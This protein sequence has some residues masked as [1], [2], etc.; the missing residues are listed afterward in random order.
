MKNKTKMKSLFIVSALVIAL[1]G[2]FVPSLVMA[3]NEGDASA[4]PGAGEEAGPS[5]ARISVA[6][7]QVSTQHADGGEWA[8][9]TVNAPLQ[10]GDSV[11]TGDRSRTEVQF[12]YSNVMRLDQN[13]AAKIADFTSSRVQIQF[14]QGLMSYSVLKGGGAEAEIDTPSV[15]VRPLGE[16]EYRIQIDPNSQQTFVTVQ[17]G[18]AEVSTPQGSQK[19]EAGQVMVIQGTDNPQFQVNNASG[20]DEFDEWSQNRD[21][22]ILEAKSW[23][24]TNRNYTGSGDLDRYGRW[25]DAPGY[26]QVWQPYEQSSDWAPYADGRW[27]WEPYYGWTWVSYEPWGWAPYH[28]GR[29]MYY[30]NAWAWWPG[31][32]YRDYYPMW[33]PAY[34]SF[35]GFGRHGGFGFG[36]G[37]IGWLPLGP[38]DGG[39]RWWGRGFNNGFNHGNIGDIGGRGVIRPMPPLAQGG[40]YPRMSNL[41]G[42]MGN[43]GV[44]RGL[45]T[46]SAQNFGSGRVQRMGS[47]VSAEALRGAQPV[48]GALPVA[49]TRQSLSP[50]G[51][52]TNRAALPAAGAVNGHFFSRGQAGTQVAAGNQGGLA[53]R[54]APPA[55]RVSTGGQTFGRGVAAPS[56]GQATAQGAPAQSQRSGDWRRFG[57][58]A[59]PQQTGSRSAGSQSF[60]SA[61]R[62]AAPAQRSAPANSGGWRGFSQPAPSQGPS[63]SAGN[64]APSRSVGPQAQPEPSNWGRSA[65]QDR[66][67]SSAPRSQPAPSNWGRSAPQ[68]QSAPAPRGGGWSSPAP[69]SESYGRAPLGS[70]RPIVT[71]QRG[72]YGNGGGYGGGGRAP[73]GGGGGYRAPSGGYGGGGGR[74]PSGGGGGGGRSSGGSGGGR[75]S[76]GSGGGHSK[77]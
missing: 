44:R 34:V 68:S 22:Q 64:S 66:P 63:R 31:L 38:H 77:H 42:A 76:G 51:S 54:T 25:Q 59:A 29:W 55:A 72:S 45:T 11:S 14:G 33:A 19:V 3:D 1:C 26:G 58:Q 74:A 69:R 50:S 13:S 41:E 61:P 57:T 53:N 46:T 4:A 7:G 28:Y 75:S 43:A 23:D 20:R 17:K 47:P 32:L 52:F 70:S 16:G 2:L 12:D 37:S 36:F 8:A 73:S 5:V 6:Q 67:S 60:P 40:R 35:Y 21:H 18:E 15:A 10:R 9:S 39:Y 56:Q 49:T 62:Q 71:P 27:T 24:H 65:P 30:N 48:Q